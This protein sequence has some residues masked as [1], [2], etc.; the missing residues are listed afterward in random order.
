MMFQGV[1]RPNK[2]TV[3]QDGKIGNLSTRRSWYHGRQPEEFLQHDN[4]CTCRDVLDI[5]RIKH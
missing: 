1:D 3:G 2:T 5:V 4:H